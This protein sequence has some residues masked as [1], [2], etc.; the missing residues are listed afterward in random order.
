MFHS[1]D[2]RSS[3]ENEGRFAAHR[4]SYVARLQSAIDLLA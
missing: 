2:S 4:Q 3:T 1:G